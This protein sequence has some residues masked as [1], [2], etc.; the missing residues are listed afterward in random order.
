MIPSYDR[1]LVTTDFSDL[2][3]AA[4]D[5]A[6]AL[7]GSRQGTVVLCHVLERPTPPNPL[8][9]HYAPGRALTPK[10]R[11][12]LARELE[13]QLREL[14][15]A[16]VPRSAR[17]EVRVLDRPGPV[18]ESIVDLAK[19]IRAKVLVIASHGR[20]GLG[21]ALLGSTADRVLRTARTPVLVVRS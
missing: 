14:V 19:A 5:H 10:E 20:S 12:A 17:T 9:A 16:G 3:D 4:I 7:L 2:G 15:P 18:H 11:K 13:Q 21:R 8:Y 1:I 6:Y